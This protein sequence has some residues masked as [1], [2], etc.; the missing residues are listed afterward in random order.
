MTDSKND[1]R[2]I[3]G[4]AIGDVLDY[5][6][7]HLEELRTIISPGERDRAAIVASSALAVVGLSQ[8]LAAGRD[9]NDVARLVVAARAMNSSTRIEGPSGDAIGLIATVCADRAERTS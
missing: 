9:E 3:C 7:R 4:L 8:L 6:I 1:L 5:Q 2:R